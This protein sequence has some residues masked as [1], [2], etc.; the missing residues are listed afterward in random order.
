MRPVLVLLA[1]LVAAPVAGGQVFGGGPQPTTVA[2]SFRANALLFGERKLL[3][4]QGPERYAERPGTSLSRRP[5]VVERDGRRIFARFGGAGGVIE[6]RLFA[7][8]PD[9]FSYEN[10]PFRYVSYVLARAR[11]GTLRPVATNSGNTRRRS[12]TASLNM[13][14]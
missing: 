5:T 9:A 2:T 6:R 3:S 4:W 10:F 13:R 11:G 12:R 7:A 1:V 8:E 14:R